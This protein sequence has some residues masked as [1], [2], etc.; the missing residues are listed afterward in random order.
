MINGWLCDC[1]SVQGD[2][3]NP[4]YV[5]HD[6]ML[7]DNEEHAW[8]F[9]KA[10]AHLA[11]FPV[12]KNNKRSNGQEYT[13]SYQG[14]HKNCPRLNRKTSKTSKR[15]GCKAMVFAKTPRDG[16]KT[17]YARVIIEHN[18]KLMPSPSLV[19]KMRCHKIQDD[20]LMSLVDTLHKC[21]VKHQNCHEC[22]QAHSWRQRKHDPN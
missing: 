12:K 14:K 7:F 16:G 13:C 21:N 18:H 8:Q 11:G 17:F 20:S 22:D 3:V 15:S 9:Y 5:P 10:Y 4:K 6:E 19:R 2:A 1:L